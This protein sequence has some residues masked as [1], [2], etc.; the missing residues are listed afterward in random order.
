[1]NRKLPTIFSR[2]VKD[3]AD[4][5]L[6]GSVIF[7][8]ANSYLVY[9]YPHNL[10]FEGLHFM[11]EAAIVG[12]IAD[13]FAVTAIFKHPFGI[14]I[15]NTAILPKNRKHFAKAAAKFVNELLNE[16]TVVTEIRNVNIIDIISLKLKEQK[17]RER[18]IAYI[19][20]II[21]ERLAKV[22]CNDN[23]KAISN[24]IRQK[25]LAY[26]TKD[27]LRYGI[28]WFKQ[29][30]NGAMVLEWVS[31][32]LKKEVNSVEFQK[33]LEK[34]YQDIKENNASGITSFFVSALETLNILNIN[35][36][37]EA[38][39]SE[40]SIL[41]SEL[42]IRDSEVQRKVLFLINNNADNI[43]NDKRLIHSL[44][45]FRENL[46]AKLPLEDAI[47]D[48]LSK[49][50]DD[51]QQEENRK[52]ITERT[53]NALRSH[54]ADVLSNQFNLIVD[55]LRNDSE[56][57]RDL[58]SFIK[59]IA[60]GFATDVAR[61]KIAKIVESVLDKMQDEQ[62]N[63]IIRSKVSD[64]LMFIRINGVRMGAIIGGMIFVLTKLYMFV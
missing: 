61:R 28:K 26:R 51:F 37:A 58:D 40:L 23:I 57:Q 56:L 27:I 5:W 11:A 36:A 2:F 32:I 62:L 4:K 41:V 49:L 15:P 53:E 55:L 33:M 30:Q 50:L 17:S 34:S 47:N 54:I 18:M 25:L 52:I 13:L 63:N 38:T 9:K 8:I 29:K 24:Q 64:D 39:Q 48:I 20:D 60:S 35:D 59:G 44:D 46:I 7:F 21:K 31:P 1:M 6:A 42:G 45:V 3:N 14:P 10:F 43:V 22:N 19:L 16:E 12:G